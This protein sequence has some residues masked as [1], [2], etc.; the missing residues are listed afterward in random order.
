[1]AISRRD[2][3]KI[4]AFAGATL[5]VGATAHALLKLQGFHKV[6]ETHQLMGTIVNF[7]IVAETEDIAHDAIQRTLNEMQRLIQMFDYRQANSPLGELNSSGI[8]YHAPPE[9]VNILRQALRFSVL[10][11]GAFDITVKPVIDALRE[12]RPNWQKLVELVDYRQL[13]VTEDEISLMHPGMSITLDGIAKGRVVDGGV[14]MLRQLGF[15][16]VLVEAGGDMMAT[17][18]PTD[19]AW[20]IGIAHPRR[21]GDCIA[22]IALR[23]RAVATSGDY[24]NYFS[25]DY[26]IYHI[27]DPRSGLSPSSLASAT[28]IAPSVA[29]ADALSTTLMVLGAQDGLALIE[30]LSDVDALVVTKDLNIYRSSAFPTG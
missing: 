10:S 18:T 20:R 22:M 3:L 16:N 19:T 5:G 8:T 26:S 15:E 9:L 30:K 28:V 24:M 6:A 13:S 29:E 23:D 25:D 11:Q 21:Q 27:I 17:G 7:V 1:M 2:F 12:D 14:A 4:T